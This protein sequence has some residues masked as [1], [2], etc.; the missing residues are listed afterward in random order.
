MGSLGDA[1]ACAL[2]TSGDT[3]AMGRATGVVEIWTDGDDS[4]GA[5]QKLHRGPVTAL[6]LLPDGRVASSAEGEPMVL[7]SPTTDTVTQLPTHGTI[8]T[9]TADSGRLAAGDDAGNVW[10]FAVDEVALS[11]AA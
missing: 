1:P 11:A 2:A 4:P 7:W 6:A 3:I 9:I 8:R 10:I 5:L